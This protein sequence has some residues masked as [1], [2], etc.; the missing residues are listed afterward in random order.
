MPVLTEE[1]VERFVDEGF[2]HVPEAFPRAVADECRAILWRKTGPDPEDPT[3]WTQPVV[4]IDGCADEPFRAAANT[5][6]LH[7]AL[8]QLVGPGRWVPT[9]GA[10]SRSCIRPIESSSRCC[11]GR[12]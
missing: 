7:G 9:A 2:L 12:S 5:P 1:Q 4:R 8:D 3:T 10:R 11:F 6:R